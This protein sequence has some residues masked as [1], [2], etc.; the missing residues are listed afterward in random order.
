MR[1]KNTKP[2]KCYRERRKQPIAKMI[3]KVMKR[4]RERGESMP[5]MMTVREI[6]RTKILPE[7]ALRN[8]IKTGQVQA[9]W[10]GNRAYVNYDALCRFLDHMGENRITDL[11]DV[12][13]FSGKG[14][15]DS[16]A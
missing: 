6:A 12:R 7:S 16:Y 4:K 2:K 8:L 14:E 11:P 10:S 3:T 15:R 9:V 5:K 13:K 1:N